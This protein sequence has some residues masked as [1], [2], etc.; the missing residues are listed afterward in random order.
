MKKLTTSLDDQKS[1]SKLDLSKM[2]PTIAAIP[3]QLAQTWQE[4]NT[5]KSPTEF[6]KFANI[7]TVGMGA[8]G[9]GAD[10]INSL[11]EDEF[12][13]PHI[14]V[15]DYHLPEFID[16]KSLVFLVSYSGQTA[17]TLKAAEKA[18]E[19]KAKIIVITTGGKLAEFAKKNNLSSW[20]FN[21]K[22]NFCGQ[23]RMGLGYSTLAQILILAKLGLIRFS[24]SDF[25][26]ILAVS[27][28]AGQKFGI[29]VKL[30]KNLAKSVATETF[31]KMPVIFA[32]QSL[33]ANAH[34]MVNQINENAKMPAFWFIL[35]E[36]AHH[37]LESLKSSMTSEN[38]VLVNLISEFY[39]DEIKKRFEIT[40]DLA[41]ENVVKVVDISLE[42]SSSLE[43]CFAMLV[44]SSWIS[45]YLAILDKIDP[46]PVTTVDYFKKRLKG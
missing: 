39:D 18:L 35:P 24:Q 13:I 44:F 27:L 40:K 42:A 28:D 34:I 43:E 6:S 8:S 25:Q 46:T 2:G 30:P 21:P 23:P 1:I 14:I 19:K 17:E 11:F 3:Q 38:L 26:R 29:D 45:Y 41:L 20:I 33:K 37:F 7:L 31:G 32:A 36:A 12:E 9:L 22:F 16:E 10:L 4:L 15:N 5:W